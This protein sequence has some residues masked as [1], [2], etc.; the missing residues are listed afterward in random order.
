MGTVLV[1]LKTGTIHTDE[2][3]ISRHAVV[4]ENISAIVCEDVV[5]VSIAEPVGIPRDKIVRAG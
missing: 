3:S 1:R 4:D 2:G 5:T